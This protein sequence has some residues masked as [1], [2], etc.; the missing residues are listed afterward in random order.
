MSTRRTALKT[1]AAAVSALP[2][3]G[4][5]HDHKAAAPAVKPYKPKWATA[6]EMKLMAELSDILIP[7]TDT[8]GAS[9]AKVHEFIDYT[10]APDAKRQ[11]QIR[12]GLQWFGGLKA[13]E[14]VAAL[15]TASKDLRT[16]HGR[17][18][19]LFKDL[20]IDGYY[21][22]KEGLMTELGWNGLTYL[23]EFKGC[24]H[25]EHQG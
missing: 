10:M 18:F 17:F 23:P 5:Q 14:R 13:A 25:P 11:A 19:K 9:D 15:T 16:A 1:A 21:S 22:S 6:A 8:P 4:Q 12:E 24:T 2:I 3:L 20:T 7:R